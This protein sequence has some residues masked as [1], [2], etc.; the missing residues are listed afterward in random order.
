MDHIREQIYL[1]ALLHD[2]GKLFQRADSPKVSQSNHLSAKYK[3]EALFCPQNKGEYTHQYTLWSAEFISRLRVHLQ[4]LLPSPSEDVLEYEKFIELAVKHQLPQE[5]L[6]TTERIIQEAD[7][8]ASGLHEHTIPSFPSF[9]SADTAYQ[10]QDDRLVSLLDTMGV[11]KVNLKNGT[12]KRMRI[13]QNF[14]KQFGFPEDQPTGK[15]DYSHVCN[16]LFEEIKKVQS[17]TLLSF[18]ETLL[19]LLHKYTS[20]VPSEI[21]RLT[22]V[23]LYDHLRTTAALAVC[24]YDMMKSGE[25]PKDRFLLIGGD[26][27]GIQSYIYQIVSKNA[28][29]N[30]K[31]RSFYIRMISDAIVRYILKELN[32]YQSHIIYNSG[33]GFYILAPNTSEVKNKLQKAIHEIEQRLFEQHGTSLFVAIDSIPLSDAALLYQQ[34][35]SLSKAWGELFVKRDKKKS[36]RHNHLLTNNYEAFF[37]PQAGQNLFDCISGEE[38]KANE[39]ICSEGGLSPLRPISKQQIVLGK[40]LRD[41]DFLVIAS[42]PIKHWDTQ[43]CFE[44][45]GLGIH[46]YFLKEKEFTRAGIT[47]LYELDN[48]TIL[49]PNT[50]HEDIDF[51]KTYKGNNIIYGF[52]FYGGNELHS[53][54]ALTFEELCHSNRETENLKRLGVLRMDVDN[55]GSIFQRGLPAERGTL[56]HFAALSRMFDYYFSCYINEIWYQTGR[57][58]SLIIY[59]GGDDVFI[60]GSWDTA[61]TIARRIEQDFKEFTCNNP[62][63]SISG[64]LAL[65]TPKYP[66]MKGAEESAEEEERAKG[67]RCK[68]Q[69]KNAISFLGMPLNWTHEFPIVERLKKNIMDFHKDEVLRSAFIS[70]IITHLIN[71]NMQNHKITNYKTYWMIAYDMG[72]M[73]ER[74][75]DAKAQELIRNCVTEICGNL[76]KLNGESIIT[77]Y[78]ALE[79]WAL[80]CRWAELEIRTKKIK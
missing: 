33:G 56:A 70:K 51:I 26:I 49:K 76:S 38:I 18:T 24:L 31:G 15:S 50:K 40:K 44:P 28:A 5:Q 46:Y 16:K 63:F 59:S 9:D 58:S 41:F 35:E 54:K 47:D 57:D 4:H 55:L 67:H 21:S 73:K 71:A 3:D 60:V 61:L 27:S 42:Q 36:Q 12:W 43:A 2:I 66:I 8:L 32:L 23:S 48:V 30:L 13:P 78:H 65:I 45:I 14:F 80:A 74:V 34:G 6:T 10:K 64:G 7:R 72:R 25:N 69:E 68:D 19:H 79:L 52:F 77:S 37:T 62:Y 11:E 17:S 53:S 39:Q 20:Y 22:E 1:A 75:K 29:K